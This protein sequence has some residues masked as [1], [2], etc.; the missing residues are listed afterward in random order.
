[1]GFRFFKR[2]QIFPGLSINLSKT[3]FSF[4]FGITGAKLTIGKRGLRKT[5]GIPG[6]GMYYTTHDHWEKVRTKTKNN[7]VDAEID[8]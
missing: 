2:F 5:V 3:G 4:S 1:M 8:E 6:T 7:I